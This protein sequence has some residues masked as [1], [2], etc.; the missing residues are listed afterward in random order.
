MPENRFLRMSLLCTALALAGCASP[1]FLKFGKDAFPKT[2]PKNPAVRI[3]TLWQQSEGMDL[4]NKTARGFAGQLLFFTKEGNVPAQVDGEVR[5]FVFDDQGT[6][7]DQMKPLRTW[8]FKREAWNAHLCK[9][10]LGATYDVFIPYTRKGSHEAKCSLRVRYTP[11]GGGP[12]IYSEMVNVLLPG[13]KQPGAAES[14]AAELDGTPEIS[15]A[16][17]SA[18]VNLP[19]LAQGMSHSIQIP[20]EIEKLRTKRPAAVELT[21]EERD[22]IL[23]EARAKFESEGDGGVSLVSYEEPSTADTAPARRPARRTAPNPLLNEDAPEAERLPAASRRVNPLDEA[24]D[25]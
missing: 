12:V 4:D 20:E 16:A 23:R 3:V 24:E 1:G 13:P 2:G 10:A 7:D 25:E 21:A 6:P 22:R 17:A 14:P 9:S 18:A 8:E 5:V 19:P 15:A 11:A